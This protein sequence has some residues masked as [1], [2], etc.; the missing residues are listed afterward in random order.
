[1]FPPKSVLGV[2]GAALCWVV[3]SFLLNG[4][5]PSDFVSGNCFVVRGVLFDVLFAHI[6]AWAP[7]SQRSSS[8]GLLDHI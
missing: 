6:E 3:D 2:L 7:S 8:I 5:F 4:G 1:M